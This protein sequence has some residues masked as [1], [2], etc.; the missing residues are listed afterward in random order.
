M[1]TSSARYVIFTDLDGT[2]LDHNSYSCEP[3]R[4]ALRALKAEGIPLV[5]CTSKTRAEVELIRKELGNHDPFIVENGAAILIPRDYFPWPIPEANCAGAYQVIA[6]GAPYPKIVL[7]L[8]R[9]A[10]KCQCPVRGFHNMSVAEI[11]QQSGLSVRDAKYAKLREYDEPFE[12]LSDDPG[13]VSSLLAEIEQQNLT[14]TRGGRFYHIRGRH[15]KGQAVQLLSG[16]FRCANPQITTVGLGD[17]PNDIS[18]LE[19]VDV[20]IVLPPKHGNGSQGLGGWAASL[21][22]ADYPGPRGWNQAVLGLLN[23]D[24]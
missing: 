19:A 15:N 17:A 1:K 13:L 20:P 5:L 23:S 6:L 12:V 7:A 16:L 18:L 14:W 24:L 8:Q 10:A 11:A 4:P 2:L 3:A 21:K 22:R 9:A